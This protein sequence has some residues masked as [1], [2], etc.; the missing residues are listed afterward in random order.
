MR[1]RPRTAGETVAFGNMPLSNVTV[2][3]ASQVPG[4]TSSTITCD[5]GSSVPA[6]EN[7]VLNMHFEATIPP[8]TLVCTIVI[9]P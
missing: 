7:P 9:D 1:R 5:D 6:D 4:G 3:V 2:S 8:K